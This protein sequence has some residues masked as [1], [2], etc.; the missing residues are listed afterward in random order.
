M[1]WVNAERIAGEVLH[2][3]GTPRLPNGIA[4]DVERIIRTR[5]DIDV[6]FVPNLVLGGQKLA[7]LYSPRHLAVVVESNDI[8]T[9]RR[10]TMAHELGH[11]EIHHKAAAMQPLFDLGPEPVSYRCT[12]QDLRS[13]IGDANRHVRETIANKFA[14]ALLMPEGLVHEIWGKTK[15]ARECSVAL[16][17]SLESM[18]IRLEQLGIQYA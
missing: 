7:G 1:E 2:N 9:R 12:E 10:F 18:T 11:I 13:A 3:S 16:G 6:A 5:H 15:D 14:A 4:V 8:V 17:V